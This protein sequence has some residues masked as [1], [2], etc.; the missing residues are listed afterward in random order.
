MTK[1]EEVGQDIR[2]EHLL[3]P[4]I[5]E[6]TGKTAENKGALRKEVYNAELYAAI[7]ES[8]IPRWSPS[9]IHLYYCVFVAF[10]C[11]C[12]NGYDGSLMGSITVMPHFKMTMHSQN[13]GWQVSVM[14]S[15]YSVGSIITT[16]FAAAVSD[17]W[18]RRVGMVFGS[19]G[20]IIGSIIAASSFSLAQV[21]VGRIVLGS[22]IQFMTVAAPAYSMEIAP[23]QWR[24]R[25]TGFY[26]C[27]W[28]GGSIPAALVTFGCQYIDNNWSWRVPFICQCFACFVVLAS[29]YSIPESPRYLFAQGREQEAVDFLVKYHGNGNRH[30]RLVQLEIEEIRESIHQEIRDRQIAWWDY[31]C[32]FDTR[33]GRWRSAQVLMMGVFGQFSGNGLGYFNPQIFNELG[34]KSTA[35]QLGYNVLNS[36]LSAIGAG[37]AVSLTDRM[38]RR[39]VLVYGTFACAVMLAINGG[40]NHAFGED[41][42]NVSAGRAA[43]AFYFLFNVVNS[44]TYTPLQGVVPVEALDNR[45]RAKGLAFYGFLT[46]CLGFINTFCTPIANRTIGLNYIWV[47]VGWDCVEAVCWYF[48]GVEAQGRTLEELQWVYEQPNPVKASQHVDKVV[49][50]ADGTITEKIV[51]RNA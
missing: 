42:N 9:T 8:N 35:Q 17:R 34:V 3:V 15:L 33:E 20:I 47:F 28:F 32:L 48:F 38:P 19:F 10:C 27:G 21:T 36:V 46:G 1:T 50:Q 41:Q 24:G 25:C 12:A 23:P 43:L 16:P 6:G 45:R 5:A 40:S 51:D 37:T 4:I 7:Q 26:N 39:K 29:V 22:G 13:D 18:G 30:S 11:A 14:T 49:Q 44:F 31:R 2:E